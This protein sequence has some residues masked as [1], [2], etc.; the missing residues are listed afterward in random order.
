MCIRDRSY[1]LDT[2]AIGTATTKTISFQGG[3]VGTS[4]VS[5]NLNTTGAGSAA[6]A[7]TVSSTFGTTLT[8]DNAGDKLDF[9]VAVDGGPATAVSI[10][11]ATLTAAGLGTTISSAADLEEA[12]LDEPGREP[13]RHRGVHPQE[14]ARSLSLIHI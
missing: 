5:I 6:T 8:F 10:N 12:A 11:A 2:A 4:P 9:S 14:G 13:Q 3:A 1:S 7:G